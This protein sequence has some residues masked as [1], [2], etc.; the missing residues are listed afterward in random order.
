[1]KG[2]DPLIQLNSTPP[3]VGPG[4]YYPEYS[5]NTS[6]MPNKPTWSVPKGPKLAN[7]K[8]KWDLNQT[9]DVSSS[10]GVQQNSLKKTLPGYSTGKSVRDNPSG[11]F[12]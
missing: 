1:V 3:I 7:L 6:Q 9:Y 10:V 8:R 11:I 4:S 12:K 5:A 2:F